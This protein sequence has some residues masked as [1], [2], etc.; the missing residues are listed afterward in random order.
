MRMIESDI[1]LF[2]NEFA[3]A[4]RALEKRFNISVN[5]GNISYNSAGFN[6]KLTVKCIDSNGET[7]TDP[8]AEANAKWAVRG[9]GIDP[10]TSNVIGEFWV[11]RSGETVKVIDYKTKNSRYPLIYVKDSEHDNR[12]FKAP[13]SVLVRRA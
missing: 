7:M 5:I 4:M 9:K 12:Q 3:S 10:C 11:T 6:S 8:R 2:R 1:K 13:V